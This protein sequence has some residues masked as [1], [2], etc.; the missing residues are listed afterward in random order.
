MA[1]FPEPVRGS[2]RFDHILILFW[3]TFMAAGSQK[4]QSRP[5]QQ[6]ELDT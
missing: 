6:A 2:G 1:Q 5:E 3:K 4:L